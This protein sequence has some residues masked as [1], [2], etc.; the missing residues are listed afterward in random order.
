MDR[1]VPL[2]RASNHAPAISGSGKQLLIRYQITASRIYDWP[3]ECRWLVVARLRSDVNFPFLAVPH[4]A[5][6]G[7]SPDLE[8]NISTRINA[9]TTLASIDGIYTRN[10]R[11][12][13]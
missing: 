7:F 2:P 10:C 11:R 3:L 1:A 4:N 8:G 6:K 12:C 9:A 5:V 13:A